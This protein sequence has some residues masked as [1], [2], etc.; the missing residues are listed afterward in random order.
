MKQG[1]SKC[2]FSFLDIQNSHASPSKNR[3]FGVDNQDSNYSSIKNSTKSFLNSQNFK[4]SSSKKNNRITLPINLKLNSIH[5]PFNP[6]MEDSFYEEIYN[7]YAYENSIKKPKKKLVSSKSKKFELTIKPSLQ[8]I[9]SLKKP[10]FHSTFKLL[11]T[12]DNRE[13]LFNAQ[14]HAKVLNES[15]EEQGPLINQSNL[16]L[17]SNNSFVNNPIKLRHDIFSS[18]IKNP[19]ME[20]LNADDDIKSKEGEIK[21]KIQKDQSTEVENKMK[22]VNYLKYL[23]KDRKHPKSLIKLPTIYNKQTTFKE[24]V[25]QFSSYYYNIRIPRMLIRNLEI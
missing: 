12:S 24:P 9:T 6:V 5:Q 13:N 15:K 10:T 20:E 2:S 22:E 4:N 18:M 17:H 3:T 14:L 21:G 25:S 16:V 23:I 8:S 19:I 7:K 11:E 1:K